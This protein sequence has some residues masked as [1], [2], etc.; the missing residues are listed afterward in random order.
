MSFINSLSFAIFA[1]S[2]I[3]FHFIIPRGSTWFLSIRIARALYQKC[4]VSLSRTDSIIFF[5]CSRSGV[6][7]VI[8]TMKPSP[9]MTG[10]VKKPKETSMRKNRIIIYLCS[11]GD[12]KNK[13]KKNIYQGKWG[14]HQ[15][16]SNECICTRRFR[17]FHFLIISI[18]ECILDTSPDEEYNRDNRS[19]CDTFLDDGFYPFTDCSLSS[20]IGFWVYSY[21]IRPTIFQ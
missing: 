9:A 15:Y 19:E 20:T 10:R 11:T 14:H 12:L 13:S 6:V 18:W 1:E 4:I 8:F 3:F 17:M 7:S 5:L 16:E 2:V 21:S